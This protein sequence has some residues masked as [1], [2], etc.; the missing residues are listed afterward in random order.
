MIKSME[1]FCEGK[2]ISDHSEHVW[3][4]TFIPRLKKTDDI[5]INQNIYPLY[6]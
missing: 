1:M 2:K 6:L 5:E 4:R 3:D